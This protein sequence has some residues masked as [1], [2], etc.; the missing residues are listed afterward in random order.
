MCTTSCWPVIPRLSCFISAGC[1]HI[2]PRCYQT[3]A[4]H[5]GH[6]SPRGAG[7]SRA[8]AGDEECGALGAGTIA[9]SCVNSAGGTLAVRCE[10]RTS[11]SRSPLGQPPKAKKRGQSE[12]RVKDRHSDFTDLQR[13]Q[14]GDLVQCTTGWRQLAP[15][16]MLG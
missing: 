3:S 5:S 7:A 6:S 4:L 8:L 1:V 13:K 10:G 9:S 11:S 14:T 2:A 16:E 15:A 12:E